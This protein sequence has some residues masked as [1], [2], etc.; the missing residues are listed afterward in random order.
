MPHFELNAIKIVLER[1][2]LYS[3][4]FPSNINITRLT[5]NEYTQAQDAIESLSFLIYSLRLVMGTE[6][7]FKIP[8]IKLFSVLMKF[9]T[10]KY[11]ICCLLS[12]ASEGL[13]FQNRSCISIRKFSVISTSKTQLNTTMKV[14]DKSTRQGRFKGEM[15]EFVVSNTLVVALIPFF[16]FY[17]ARR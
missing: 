1:L 13:Q 11:Y 3:G 6:K 2:T 14:E 9:F 4:H 7:W 16:F 12:M 5:R 15:P 17:F 10:E 8:S